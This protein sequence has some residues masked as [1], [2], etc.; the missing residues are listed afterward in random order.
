[1]DEYIVYEFW[2]EILIPFGIFYGKKILH[3]VLKFKEII[4][5]YKI[6]QSVV[7]APIYVNICLIIILFT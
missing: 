7:T 4:E 6:L 1:M 5:N 3:L 2:N